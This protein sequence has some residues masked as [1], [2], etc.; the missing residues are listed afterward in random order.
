MQGLV[1]PTDVALDVGGNIGI[2]ATFLAQRL[3]LG[4]VFSFE[5]IPLNSGLIEG[6]RLL[7]L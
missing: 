4:K 7:G 3:R 5:P 6:L 2:Y 1:H